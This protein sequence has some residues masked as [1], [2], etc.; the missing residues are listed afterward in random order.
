MSIWKARVWLFYPVEAWVEG[1]W[2]P[3]A[4]RAWW[5]RGAALGKVESSGTGGKARWWM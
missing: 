1:V 5:R 2:L 4:K 3:A